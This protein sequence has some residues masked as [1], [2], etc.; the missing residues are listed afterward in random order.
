MFSDPEMKT[1]A[2]VQRQDIVTEH[3]ANAQNKTGS[4]GQ[5]IDVKRLFSIIS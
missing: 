1:G 5:S 3:C 4:F 2:E